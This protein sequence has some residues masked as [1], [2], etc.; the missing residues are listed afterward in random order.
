MTQQQEIA[1]M[2][3]ALGQPLPPSVPPPDQASPA[4]QINS[5]SI[6]RTNV[7]KEP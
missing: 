3:L 5:E 2:R 4:G 7:A 6:H 1:A